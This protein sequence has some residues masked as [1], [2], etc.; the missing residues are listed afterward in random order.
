MPNT[1]F[2]NAT[3]YGPDDSL[4]SAVT[5]SGITA[6]DV[7]NVRF[8]ID[9]NPNGGDAFCGNDAS[10]SSL[11]VTDPDG[12]TITIFSYGDKSGAGART[13]THDITSSFASTFNGSY[14]FNLEDEDAM[15]CNT[16]DETRVIVTTSASSGPGSIAGLGVEV[17]TF[18]GPTNNPAIAGLGA[19]VLTFD[20]PSNN[21]SVAGLGAEVLTFDGPTNN[22]SVAALGIE[23]LGVPTG[24]GATG[25][26]TKT[27][28]T[29]SRDYST[30][31]LWEADLDSTS[32]YAADAEAVGECYNDS[33]FAPF[34]I[35]GGDSIT[36]KS[37]TLKAAAGEVHDGTAGT[38]VKVETTANWQRA[39]YLGSNGYTIPV[40]V[41]G[42][43]IV[44]AHNSAFSGIAAI[45]SYAHNK[46]FTKCIIH[47]TYEAETN[48]FVGLNTGHW[49][50]F[51]SNNVI[52]NVK[53]G[54]AGN[55]Y[56]T[57]SK[58]VNNTINSNNGYALSTREA[59]ISKNTIKNNLLFRRDGLESHTIQG[60][61]P[62]NVAN[63]DTNMVQNGTM[64]GSNPY[65]DVSIDNMFISIVVGSEDYHLRSQFD[66]ETPSPAIGIGLNL[67]SETFLD[68]GVATGFHSGLA[69]EDIDS[70]SRGQ[71]WDIGADQTP[72]TITKTIGT[73]SRDYSTISL[74]EA[75]LDNTDVYF[76][77]DRAIGECYN[78]STFT[79]TFSLNSGSTIGLFSVNLT[80]PKSER[81][82]GTAGSGVTITQPGSYQ[83]ISVTADVPVSFE[84]LIFDQ[85]GTFGATMTINSASYLFHMSRC[86]IHSGKNWM[87]RN[88]STAIIDNSIFYDSG[89]SGGQGA[90]IFSSGGTLDCINNTLVDHIHGITRDAGTVTVVNSIVVSD[91]ASGNLRDT[92]FSGTITQKYNASSDSSASGTGSLTSQ[93]FDLTMFQSILAGSEDYHLNPESSAVRAGYNALSD[94]ASYATIATDIDGITRSAAQDW[95]MGADQTGAGGGMLL[96]GVG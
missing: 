32:V 22:P 70:L 52:Y 4:S 40:K 15:G 41:E 49:K 67:S 9:W 37:V 72:T 26:V 31:S 76:Y 96:L 2:T 68:S 86:I 20:G 54:L 25:V 65:T 60:S 71:N 74:W 33:T 81:H 39:V 75:D 24:G 21:P 66:Y 61:V 23:I 59:N 92:D 28:G 5:V 58:Y 56:Y 27:I 16:I 69:T 7:T 18:S 85:A 73:S 29:N 95:D 35:N 88:F 80:A 47:S 82:D 44:Q 79:E 13:D 46:V 14:T 83:K 90:S 10:G 91:P 11:T 45:F 89:D 36:L 1:T 38:G 63:W 48:G 78:D 6:G 93:A 94:Y 17:L 3:D 62:S 30:I 64:Y 53:Y 34:T 84:Y 77:E 19:E 51:I 50:S 8:E 55:N 57:G 43:E 42:I 87:V 12:S